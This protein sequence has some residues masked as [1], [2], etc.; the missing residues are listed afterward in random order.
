MYNMTSSIS[1]LQFL[2]NNLSWLI[3]CDLK[4]NIHRDVISK[5]CTLENRWNFAENLKGKTFTN[6]WNW[7]NRVIRQSELRECLVRSTLINVDLVRHSEVFQMAIRM[8]T[9][10]CRQ[11]DVARQ[12]NVHPS[13]FRLYCYN[14][15]AQQFHNCNQNRVIM[16]HKPRQS[17]WNSK[18]TVLLWGNRGS[19]GCAISE[20]GP[21]YHITTR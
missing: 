17:E 6:L 7:H 20:P 9:A 12:F 10:L 21:S 18:F 16:E 2:L 8:H 11:Q 13:T 4:A 14:V 15:E 5:T 19:W 1:I 3:A